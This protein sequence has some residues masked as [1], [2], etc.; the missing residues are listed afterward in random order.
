MSAPGRRLDPLALSVATLF[1]IGRAPLVP[2]TVGSLAAVPL[3]LAAAWG[4]PTWGF[5]VATTAVILLGIWAAGIAVRLL[6]QPD[7]TMV[8][9]DEVAGMFIAFAG[10]PMQWGTLA[11]AFALFRIL[12]VLKPPPARQ[13]ERLRGGLGVVLDDLLAGLYANLLL[14]IGRMLLQWLSG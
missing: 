14:R 4:L 13:A 7:P 1:G 12:D 5:A 9:I 3:V 10:L 11:A 6:G 2:G 8:V